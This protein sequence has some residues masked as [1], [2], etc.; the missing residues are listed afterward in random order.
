MNAR[1]EH[2]HGPGQVDPRRTGETSSEGAK[3]VKIRSY[4]LPRVERKSTRR[5]KLEA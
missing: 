2:S 1:L 5:L 3:E 4:N